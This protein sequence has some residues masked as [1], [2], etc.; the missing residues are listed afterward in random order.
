MTQSIVLWG[1]ESLLSP[2]GAIPFAFN[3]RRGVTA[4]V[5][6]TSNDQRER[7][8]IIKFN[9]EKICDIQNFKL[10]III[11]NYQLTRI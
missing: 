11:D 5:S 2:G 6:G 7:D 1:C 9:D 3:N 8:S 10:I 4:I